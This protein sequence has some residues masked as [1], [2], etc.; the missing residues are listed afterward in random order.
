MR[1][2][3]WVPL[4]KHS[5][6]AAQLACR[7]ASLVRHPPHANSTLLLNL[8][9]CH[10]RLYITATFKPMNHNSFKKKCIFWLGEGGGLLNN[11]QEFC[12]EQTFNGVHKNILIEPQH[13]LVTKQDL[14]SKIPHTGNIESLDRCGS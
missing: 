9:R 5:L 3:S 1:V 13:P 2:Y 12:G 10:P 4:P 14:V 6:Q 8:P 7:V 11:K